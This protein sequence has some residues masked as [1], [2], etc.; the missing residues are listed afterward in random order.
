LDLQALPCFVAAVSVDGNVWLFNPAGKPSMVI[1]AGF[2]PFMNSILARSLFVVSLLGGMPSALSGG[3][4]AANFDDGAGTSSPDQYPGI[5]GSGWSGAWT[6]GNLSSGGIT[7]AIETTPPLGSGGNHLRVALASTSSDAGIGRAF[8]N[9]NG[10]SG[11]DGT[12]PVTFEFDVRLDSANSGFTSS[13]DYL[14]I[15]N[16]TGL[17]SASGTATWII[18][19]VGG[20]SPQWQVYNG[21]RDGGSFNAGLL[22]NSGMPALAGTTYSFTVVADPVSRSYSTTISN[23]TTDVTVPNMGFRTSATT[24]GDTFGTFGKKD[25]SGDTLA[26]AIDSIA[27]SGETPP[28]PPP[29]PATFPVVFDMVHHNPGEPLYQSQFNSPAFTKDMGFNGKVFFLFESAQLAVNWDGFDTA[30]K[31]ILPVGSPDR[32]WVDAKR[33]EITAKYDAAKAEGLQVF[34]MSDLVLFPKRLVSLYGMSGTMGN[35]NNADTELWLRRTMNLMF[36]QFPQLDGI[37]V[38]IGETYLN[39]APYHQGEID[40]KNDANATIIPLM[41]ILRDEVCVKLNKKIYFRT[42]GS[43]DTDLST[44]LAVSNGVEPHPNLTWS[45]KHCEG[46]FHR[47]NAYSKVMGQG[48]HPFIVEVQCAREYEGKGALPNYIA[49]GVIEGF[50]E[51]AANPTQSLRHLWQNSPLMRGV[52][53]WSRGGGWRGPYIRNEL[54]CELNAWVMAQWALDP[55]ATELSLFNRFATEKLGLPASQLGDFRQLA[56]LSAKAAWRWKRGTNNSLVTWWSRDEYY[57]YPN[58]PSSAAALATM[59]ADQDEAVAEFA[60]IVA[61]ARS[62]TPADPA[63]REFILSSSLYGLHLMEILRTVK[64]LKA[65]EGVDPVK[66][67]SWLDRHDEAW[68]A[69]LDLANQFP[70]SISTFYTRNA[71]QTSGGENPVTAEPRIRATV[72]ALADSDND[73]LIDL[74]ENVPA[75]IDTDNDGIPDYLDTDSD[76]DGVPDAVEIGR[77]WDDPIDS[78]NDGTPDFRDATRSPGAFTTWRQEHFARQWNAEGAAAW[79]ANP[80]GDAYCNGLE[81]AL[82]GNPSGRDFS[83]SSLD[84]ATLELHFRRNTAATDST[85]TVMM[86]QDMTHWVGVASSAHGAPFVPLVSGWHADETA[87]NGQVAVGRGAPTTGEKI[88]LRISASLDGP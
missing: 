32:A 85:I 38:R 63:D 87:G 27:I 16:N 33:A 15:H 23:G 14:T 31:V 35:V 68:S 60:E 2:F 45:V 76:N 22:V 28:P 52:W 50:E 53:T 41:N 78:N 8:E 57:T 84:P 20:A 4:V 26:Y 88:F 75:G 46:D 74:A 65:N 64:N 72:D 55:A 11:V 17:V 9:G 77:Y 13:N 73:G 36:T 56:L 3:V 34:A 83:L 40:N 37:M 30:D 44:F 10:T 49:N 21:N 58:L 86:S 61:I 80:D 71:W 70:D 66:L 69:Y 47:G 59:L 12:K 39:D 67:K 24:I 82:V 7:A 42:W 81:Y 48:R 29:P 79:L 6:T 62:L 25:S 5:A 18:R 54:W 51:H 43:F 19:V 1:P